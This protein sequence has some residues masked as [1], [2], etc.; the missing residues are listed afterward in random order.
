MI[1]GTLRYSPANADSVFLCSPHYCF[2]LNKAILP[3]QQI[4]ESLF[5]IAGIRGQEPGNMQPRP[6][7]PVTVAKPKAQT[8]LKGPKTLH[9]AC[10]FHSLEAGGEGQPHTGKGFHRMRTATEEALWLDECSVISIQGFA[11]T[12][13]LDRQKIAEPGKTT[14]SVEYFLC[15][16][17]ILQTIKQRLSDVLE[18]TTA[19]RHEKKQWGKTG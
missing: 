12:V 13:M 19:E 4:C 6:Q 8:L 15:A 7:P 18:V 16:E 3:L 11:C 14:V 2:D 9:H 5:S 1:T 10:A 17:I